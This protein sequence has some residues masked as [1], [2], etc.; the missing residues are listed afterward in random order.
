ME[1]MDEFSQADLEVLLFML[2]RLDARHD[3]FVVAAV[4]GKGIAA[5]GHC[6][7]PNPLA[8][9]FPAAPPAPAYHGRGGAL[10]AP[11]PVSA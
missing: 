2:D 11:A 7:E 4:H 6:A 5:D 3:R 1:G 10:G 8:A 9:S